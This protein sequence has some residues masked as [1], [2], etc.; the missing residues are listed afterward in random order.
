VRRL[1][2]IVS[3]EDVMRM[4]GFPKKKDGDGAAGSG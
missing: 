2:G 1:E 3:L 4:Y